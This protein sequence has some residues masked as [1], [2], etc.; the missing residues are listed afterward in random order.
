MLK[1]RKPELVVASKPKFLISGKAGIGKTF[2][3]LDFPKP[4]LIDTEGGATRQQ[5]QEKLKAVGGAYFGKE[6]G[7][8]DFQAVIKEIEALATQKHDYKTLIIDSFTYLYL[9]EAAKAEQE[10]G[11]DFG[12]DRKEANKPT[13][14]MIRWLER[15]DMNVILVCHSK[16]KWIRRGKEIYSEGT[17]FDGYDKLEYILDLWVE[18]T[19]GNYTPQNDGE[20]VV[21][22][23][24]IDSFPMGSVHPLRYDKFAEIYGK[25]IIEK[26]TTPV[27]LASAEQVERIKQLIEV[28]KIEESEIEK[29][30]SKGGVDE[31][32]EMT[33]EQI[34]KC[35]NFLTKKAAVLV[36]NGK[37]KRK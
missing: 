15:V 6:E 27:V 1:A 20:F 13:R 30:F 2:F 10:I 25:K 17:I 5:Y 23:S 9:L 16:E 31:W 18:I 29:W 36:G 35:I 24:R 3:A 26:E 37:E 32:K 21:K 14:Q 8:Q 12:R 7:S 33:S 4:Y 22:K 28:V 19:R 11:S 34:E